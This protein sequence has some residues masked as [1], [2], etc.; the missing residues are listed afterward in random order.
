MIRPCSPAAPGLH[1]LWNA[2]TEPMPVRRPPPAPGFILR[3]RYYRQDF[4]DYRGTRYEQNALG[5]QH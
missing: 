1:I 4:L 2:F 3:Y 5:G